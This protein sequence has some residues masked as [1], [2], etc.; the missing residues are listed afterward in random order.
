MGTSDKGKRKT[1]VDG[2]AHIAET[3]IGVSLNPQEKKEKGMEIEHCVT[4]RAHWT[5]REH[6]TLLS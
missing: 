2:T 1:R 5:S 3:Q 6:W 4:A